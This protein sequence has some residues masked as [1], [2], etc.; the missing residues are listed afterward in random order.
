LNGVD[1]GDV[2]GVKW[3][4]L[5]LLPLVPTTLLH[6]RLVNLGQHYSLLK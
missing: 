1:V 4:K 5:H 6:T 3:F 2:Q